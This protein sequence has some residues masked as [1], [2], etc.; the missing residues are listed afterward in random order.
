MASLGADTR[1]LIVSCPSCGQGNRLAYD[2][3]DCRTR[4]GRCQTDLPFVSG[5]LAVPGDTEFAALVAHSRLPVFVD[6]W[7]PWCG[8]CR[9]VAPE[10]ERLGQLAAGQAVIA[11]VDTEALPS[12]AARFQIQSIPT[13]VVFRGGHE[14][15]R[16][17]GAMPAPRLFE[18][19]KRSVS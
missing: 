8:P 12:I 13:F 11:K 9:S 15:H 1:G 18:W 7:A 5:V 2:R 3:L 19:L 14:I 4:C 6:F 17:S 10:I 16:T